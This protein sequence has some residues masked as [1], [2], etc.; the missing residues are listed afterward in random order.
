MALSGQL[1]DLSLA[2]LIEFFCNQRKTGRLKIAYQ[3]APGYFYFD[4]GELVDAKIGALVGVDAV[5]YALTQENASFKFSTAFEATRRTIHQPWA[6]VALE[7]L[8]RLDEGVTPKEAFPEGMAL[9][10]D[11]EPEEEEAKASTAV[12]ASVQEQPAVSQSAEPKPEQA[13]LQLTVENSSEGGRSRA[14][15][16]AAVIAALVLIVAGIGFPAGWYG[17][18]KA[19]AAAPA[20]NSAPEAKAEAAAPVVTDNSQTDSSA[21]QTQEAQTDATAASG[22]NNFALKQQQEREREARAAYLAAQEQQRERAQQAAKDNP[23]MQAQPAQANAGEV[24]KPEATA[25]AQKKTVTVQVTYDENGRVTQASGGDG[26]A[27]RIARQKRFPT[28]K[29]GSATVTIPVN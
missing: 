19:V 29:P 8:R 27:Q 17:K 1:S 20:A 15:V 23:T 26:M 2:E 25:P 10:H 6:H 3:R 5:Y 4:R 22:A 24:K 13:P 14:L 11:D 28:G 12:K 16:Y 7:G 21:A 18:R 9:V